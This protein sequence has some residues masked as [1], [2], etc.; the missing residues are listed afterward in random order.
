M[1]L[2]EDAEEGHGV[3][4]P[5]CAQVVSVFVVKRYPDRLDAVGYLV[6]HTEC[7]PPRVLPRDPPLRVGIGKC[8]GVA[9]CTV[10]VVVSKIVLIEVMAVLSGATAR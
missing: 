7:V 10:A 2:V 6:D 3:L 4:L 1:D 5:P 9:A 8:T